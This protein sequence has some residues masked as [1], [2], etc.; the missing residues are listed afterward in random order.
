MANGIGIVHVIVGCVALK[1]PINELNEHTTYFFILGLS[2]FSLKGL[3]GLDILDKVWV[4]D[5][6]PFIKYYYALLIF[7]SIDEFYFI[8]II[9]IR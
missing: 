5:T 2:I 1:C 3:T 4:N 6:Q 9:L 7:F 8:N